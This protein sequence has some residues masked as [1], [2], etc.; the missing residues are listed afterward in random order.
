MGQ[1]DRVTLTRHTTMCKIG[2]REAAV[3]HQELGCSVMAWAGAGWGDICIRIS[4]SPCCIAEINTT[5]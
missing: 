4:D 5:L 2:S 3:W 1:I